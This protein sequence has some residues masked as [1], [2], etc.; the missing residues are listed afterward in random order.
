MNTKTNLSNKLH[1]VISEIDC[2]K[3]RLRQESNS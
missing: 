3:F 1:R 2:A